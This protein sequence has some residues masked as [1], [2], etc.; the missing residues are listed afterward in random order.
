MKI[1]Q[2]SAYPEPSASAARMKLPSY[3]CVRFEHVAAAMHRIRGGIVRTSC[4]RSHW[5]SEITGSHVHFKLEQ[6]QFT[7]SFKERGARNALLSLDGEARRRGVVAASAGNHALALTWHGVQLGIP[8]TVVMPT[9][10][11]M[12]KVDKCRLFGANVVIH[13]AHIGESKQH[14]LEVYGDL[15]Y[16]N[17]Y[18]DPEIIAGTGTLGMEMLEQVPDCDAV[19]VPVGGGGLIAGIALAMKTMQPGLRVIG[20]EPKRCASYSAA[21]EAG[22]PVPVAV[23]PTLAD[24]LAVP[25]VGAHAFAVAR[26]WVDEIVTVDEAAVALAV[27]RLLEGEKMVVE[28]GGAAGLAAMLPGGPLDRLDLKV[29]AICVPSACHR[30]ALGVPSECL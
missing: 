5:L 15:R 19:V 14:A 22:H 29:R 17:G 20:V 10:A 1:R 25:Q 9:V 30:S 2:S 27:L 11:P 4:Q 21:L 18:D 3:D 8:V 7:G 23:M 12:A 6:Q 26:H 28:G 13:G 24:G 16:I